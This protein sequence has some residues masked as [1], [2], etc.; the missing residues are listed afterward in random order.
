[1]SNGDL[2]DPGFLRRLERLAVA[3]RRPSDAPFKGEH[4]SARHG[5]SV[6]FSDFRSYVPGDDFRHIDWN[7]F[8]RLEKLF[9]KLF[10]EETE[11]SVYVLLDVS[12]SM[13]LPED[14][15]HYAR[16][17]AAALAYV[18]LCNFDRVL[19][20]GLDDSLGATHGPMRGKGRA[21]RC[22][23][24]LQG[25]V[26]SGA[27]DLER[28]VLD[29]ARLRP[30]RGIVIVISDFLQE[31]DPFE[32]LK[33]LRAMRHDVFAVQVLA[34]EELDPSLGGD[35]KLVDVE[36]RAEREVTITPSV[37]DAYRDVVAR[38][39]QGIGERC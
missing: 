23:A 37:L 8:G 39:V 2:L 13:G 26:A 38:Y 3:A 25:L 4:S 19:V 14:K 32:G 35:L 17:L 24:F 11:Y 21:V 16:R 5:R 6:E 15:L 9:L 28:A 33:R 20:A 22:F 7:A 12:A 34:P 31:A 1:L 27:S 30:R 36:T 29:F 18:S 10:K